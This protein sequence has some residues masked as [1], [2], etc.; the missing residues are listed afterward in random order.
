LAVCIV[1]GKIVLR[2]CAGEQEGGMDTEI[3]NNFELFHGRLR[4]IHQRGDVLVLPLIRLSDTLRASRRGAHQ[5]RT[6]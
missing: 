5:S 1:A 6:G 2:L 3:T 4:D